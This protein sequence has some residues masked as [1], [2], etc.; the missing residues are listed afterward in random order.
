MA[1]KSKKLYT[2]FGEL[3]LVGKETLFLVTTWSETANVKFSDF[4]QN[5]NKVLIH[6]LKL[7]YFLKHEKIVTGCKNS[8]VDYCKKKPNKQTK[9]WQCNIALCQITLTSFQTQA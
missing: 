6:G 5:W 4:A 2:V 8:K 9:G 1:G 7:K 3:S